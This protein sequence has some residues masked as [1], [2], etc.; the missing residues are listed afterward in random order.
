MFLLKYEDTFNWQWTIVFLAF[1][2]ALD[3]AVFHI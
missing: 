3:P 1:D 2:P